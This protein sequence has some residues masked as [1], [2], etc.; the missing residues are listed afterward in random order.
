MKSLDLLV[1][2]EQFLTPT[3]M[4]ADYVLPVTGSLE[5]PLMQTNGGVANIAYG[6]AAAVA[7]RGERRTDFDFWN[8]LGR[9]CGQEQY[10]PWNT[11]EDALS[12]VLAP[13]GLSW[14]EF[15]Q[16][17][18]YAPEK[19]Y[20]KWTKEGFA[21]PSGKVELKA[22][23]LEEFGHDPLPAYI[24]ANE[25]DD[26]FPLRLMTGARKHP[27]YAS[28]FRQ[29]KQIRKLH[30]RPLADIS[31]ATAARFSIR[32]GDKVWIETRQ[33]RIRQEAAIVAMRDDVVSIEYGWWYPEK[34]AMEPVLGGLWESNANV[35]TTADT[36]FCDPILGGWD[37]RAIPCR[38]SKTEGESDAAI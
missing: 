34:E 33:G 4:L 3:A 13:A 6:G 2:L 25:V 30:P 1:V 8:G 28:E 31:P 11:L 22:T 36:A 27:Y 26:E 24:P 10:W 15:C 23:L 7:P 38:I 17:G 29:I 18:C 32:P 21:T 9:R 5:Q 35:L 12:D 20:R 37:F 16:T 19:E 14:S